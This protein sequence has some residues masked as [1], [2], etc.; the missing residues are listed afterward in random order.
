MPPYEITRYTYIKAKKLNVHVKPSR[1]YGKKIDVFDAKG[2]FICAVGAKGY[3]D[4][5][6]FLREDGPEVA[7]RRRQMYKLRHEK[8]RHHVG[9]PGW[10]ADKLLW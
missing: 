3:K 1:S 10:F 9:S 8:D 5:P 4:F 7:N 2:N 6:T